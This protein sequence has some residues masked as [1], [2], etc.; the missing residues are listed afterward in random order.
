MEKSKRDTSIQERQQTGGRRQYALRLWE[1]F[2]EM[3][4]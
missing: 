2:L 4:Y 3:K 1:A